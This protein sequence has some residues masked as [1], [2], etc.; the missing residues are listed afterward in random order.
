MN[1]PDWI[2]E[3]SERPSQ[4]CSTEEEFVAQFNQIINKD[5]PR[6][7][8]ALNTTME[9]L[10]RSRDGVNKLIGIASQGSLNGFCAE[11]MQISDI[12][13]AALNSINNPQEVKC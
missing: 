4:P 2:N 1:K 8:Q 11:L 7:V 3:I 9:V 12:N 6:L 5:I 13:S 10:E